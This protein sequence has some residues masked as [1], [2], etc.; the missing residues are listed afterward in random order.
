[1][2]CIIPDDLTFQ[3]HFHCYMEIL[4]QSSATNCTRR[5]PHGQPEPWDLQHTR[6]NCWHTLWSHI[7]TIRESTYHLLLFQKNQEKHAI[8]NSIKSFWIRCLA[9]TSLEDLLTSFRQLVIVNF[10]LGTKRASKQLE[11]RACHVCLLQCTKKLAALPSA[12]D[13]QLRTSLNAT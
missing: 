3:R 13:M 1:M 8:S 5:K 7:P 12:A 6:R 11:T 9:S 10:A 4:K 2:R